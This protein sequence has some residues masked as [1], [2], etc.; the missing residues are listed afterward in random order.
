MGQKVLKIVFLY[1]KYLL[2]LGHT[3]SEKI[4]LNE[5][6][7]RG[8]PTINFAL[9]Q[10]FFLLFYVGRTWTLGRV[11]YT[12]ATVLQLGQYSSVVQ[13]LT[14]GYSASAGLVCYHL[15]SGLLYL[16]P[17]QCPEGSLFS[18]NAFNIPFGGSSCLVK[19]KATQHFEVL[20]ELMSMTGQ[21]VPYTKHLVDRSKVFAYNQKI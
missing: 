13:S 14:S 12:D 1:Q 7:F 10:C 16:T 6:R 21:N 5:V 15:L 9:I 19:R 18:S 11:Q 4:I 20:S 17:S 8:S 2:F 3:L